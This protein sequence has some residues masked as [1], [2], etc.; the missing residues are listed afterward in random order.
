GQGDVC[1]ADADGDFML[2]PFDCDDMDASVNPMALEVC[3]GVTDEDCDELV[4]ED[5]PVGAEPTLCWEDMDASMVYTSLTLYVL[6]NVGAPDEHSS[7]PGGDFDGA[8][9]DAGASV[10]GELVDM[11]APGVYTLTVNAELVDGAGTDFACTGGSN[12][13]NWSLGGS[14]PLLSADGTPLSIDDSNM[15]P[16]A[17]G[18]G[19]DLEFEIVISP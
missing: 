5:C 4:D 17:M 12:P 14:D 18:T 9:T 8:F 1:D 3:D 2:P 19:C 6:W 11:T 15:V 16:N 13:L 10:C 7:F